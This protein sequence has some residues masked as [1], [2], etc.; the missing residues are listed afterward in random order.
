MAVEQ[1]GGPVLA[2]FDV[3]NTLVHGASA[4]HLVRGLRA[5]GLITLRDIVSAGWKHARFKVRGEDDRHLAAA[6]TRGLEVIT[7][8]TVTDMARLADDV[9]ERHTEPSVWPETAALAREHLAKGH[10]VWLVTATP[11]FLADVI[12]RSLGLTGALG[13]VFEVQDG[14]YTGRLDG[15]FLHGEQKAVAA[16][17]LLARTGADPAICWAYSDSRHDIPLLSLVGNP[18][19][20]NPDQQ[21]ATHART[22]GWPSMR[23]QRASIRQARRRVRREAASGTG[24][25]TDTGTGTGTGTGTVQR[26]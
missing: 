11:T 16:R 7:G 15:A 5:A 19:V 10:Q 23:L 25:A 8:I 21:L 26:S 9:W 3:D 4:F 17:A 18:V 2:L 1:T 22:A 20:V 12:A 13:S 6:Q 24:T 14:V